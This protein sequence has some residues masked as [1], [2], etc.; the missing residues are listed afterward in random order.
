[1][2]HNSPANRSPAR[3]L[4]PRSV[5]AVDASLTEHLPT[6]AIAPVWDCE[7]ANHMAAGKSDEDL[8]NL[9]ADEFYVDDEMIDNVT[10]EEEQ[11]R[12]LTYEVAP[13]SSLLFDISKP[14]E[15]DKESA[16]CSLFDPEE[17]PAMF[18]RPVSPRIERSPTPE[19]LDTSELNLLPTPVGP[20]HDPLA[21]MLDIDV[22]NN[23]VQ[24][25]VFECAPKRE[26][27]SLMRPPPIF[28]DAQLE[29]LEAEG[30]VYE[31]G[32]FIKKRAIMHLDHNDGPRD[33]EVEFD[34]VLRRITGHA[35]LP[36]VQHLTNIESRSA[37]ITYDSDGQVLQQAT[38]ELFADRIDGDYTCLNDKVGTVLIPGD[39]F[40]LAE[41]DTSLGLSLEHP[42][43]ASL[44]QLIDDIVEDE[45]LVPEP[46]VIRRPELNASPGP[47]ALFDIARQQFT[48]ITALDQL[49]QCP[50]NVSSV[51]RAQ[52]DA[53]DNVSVMSEDDTDELPT[54]ELSELFYFDADT[55]QNVSYTAF[56]QLLIDLNNDEDTIARI[57]RMDTVLEEN[58]TGSDAGLL[59]IGE[60]PSNGTE[61]EPGNSLQDKSAFDDDVSLE[62]DIP[63][64]QP[65]LK[66]NNPLTKTIGSLH[67]ST[68][69]W[70]GKPLKRPQLTISTEL[71]TIVEVSSDEDIAPLSASS[72]SSLDF[73]DHR[74]FVKTLST[75]RTNFLDDEDEIGGPQSV[76]SPYDPS[77][78]FLSTT[79]SPTT[80]V[81]NYHEVF[82][83]AVWHCEPDL[84]F[85]FPEND[86]PP[87][88]DRL[89]NP[90]ALDALETEIYALIAFTFQ[91]MNDGQ[92]DQLPT[93]GSDLNWALSA[94]ADE[95]PSFALLARLGSVVDILLGRIATS[96][97]N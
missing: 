5:A 24:E 12:F 86:P 96:G 62:L 7:K 50:P 18:M 44:L 21:Q 79:M 82:S 59:E 15:I 77:E 16:L 13:M 45:L 64:K 88:N 42:T 37:F 49:L 9:Y 87:W 60:V 65:E 4:N 94:L 29:E 69:V 1:M 73:A 67:S 20:L 92:L 71:S 52:F 2:A 95:F 30:Y 27:R 19:L 91:C 31:Q 61:A 56:N 72:D 84:H 41:N 32:K 14:D 57:H 43:A 10:I 83:D 8:V 66:V 11:P 58:D 23:E 89:P 48:K 63:P 28:T 68:Y 74:G 6:K 40:L 97:S 26:G 36:G 34:A 93:L 39:N 53:D 78:L 22:Y 54:L 47:G 76:R 3:D 38:A 33:W 51:V 85:H 46:L 81:E 80:I 17:L 55:K 90:N 35:F 25:T 75:R 70:R